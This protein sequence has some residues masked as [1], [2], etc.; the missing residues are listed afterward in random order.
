MARETERHSATN[1]GAADDRHG[2]VP[3]DDRRGAVAAG[4]DAPRAGHDPEHQRREE[5]GGFNIGAAFFGWL[6][7][8]AMT[9]LLVAL[10]SAAGAAIGLTELSASE[11]TSSA[12][13][14]GI[15][16]AALLLLVLFLAY[17]CG[18][19]VAGRM[20][21][22]DGARQGLGVWLIGLRITILLAVAGA[23]FGAEYNLLQQAD[24]WRQV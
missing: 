10:I 11:A 16:G 13:T 7:A 22:Y 9:A 15:V 3:A 1:A 14:I 18:G 2:A 12:E 19:Y 21:R 17:L 4:D 24:G 6:V 23:I 5:Y 20:S 8:I